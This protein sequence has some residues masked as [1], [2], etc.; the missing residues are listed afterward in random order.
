MTALHLNEQYSVVRLDDETL[1]VS[2]PADK[3]SG[4]EARK[5]RVPLNKISR[6]IIHGSIT[7]TT[8]V[9]W[10]LLERHI[11]ITYLTRSGKFIGRTSGEEHKF[12]YLRLIQRRT[13]DDPSTMLYIARM[14]VRSKLH[15][16]RTLLLR[17]NR[18]RNNPK[19]EKA[20]TLIGAL[21]E[22]IDGLPDEDIS[23]PNPSRP[24]AGTILGKLMG[25]EGKAATVYFAV[26]GLLFP[27]EW[28][29]TF[30][31]RRKRP[32]TDPINAML[33]FGYTLLTSRMTAAVYTVGFDPYIGYL[34]STQYGNPALALDLVEMFRAPVVD[35]VVLTMINNRMVTLEDFE[36]QMGGCRMNDETRKRFLQ[37]FEER[38]QET[39]THPYL[40]TKA[41]YERCLELQVRLL[42]RWMLGELRRFREFHMR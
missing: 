4:R 32:P 36:M 13:H 23:P 28:T 7:P 6:V 11:E 19:V 26:L 42:S 12:G 10:A 37:K 1:I 39:I 9:I 21:I 3:A 5:V 17:S 31:G 25:L 40:K 18:T 30:P 27:E 29:A 8:P 14:C 24:Q 38:L 34:H 2:I 35:S 15:N 20:A 33:S 22:R 41:T 16:Q